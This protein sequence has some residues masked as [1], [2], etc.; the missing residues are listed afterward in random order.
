MLWATFIITSTTVGFTP[1]YL[2]EKVEGGGGRERDTV[3]DTDR[4][5]QRETA[6]QRQRGGERHKET[7][8]LQ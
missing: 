2:F 4:D 3:R 5:G 7:G 1:V 8:I 6:W